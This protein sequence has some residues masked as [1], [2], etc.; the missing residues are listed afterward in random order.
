MA[1]EKNSNYKT[2]K[3]VLNI[4]VKTKVKCKANNE[5]VRLNIARKLVI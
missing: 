1:F 2:D 4:I 3:K 5:E